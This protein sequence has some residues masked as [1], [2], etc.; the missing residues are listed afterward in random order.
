MRWV[1]LTNGEHEQWRQKPNLAVE[2]LCRGG[3]KSHVQSI[4]F[5]EASKGREVVSEFSSGPRVHARAFAECVARHVGLAGVPS[6]AVGQDEFGA[7]GVSLFII[8]DEDG[9]EEG[10]GSDRSA[11]VRRL[12]ARGL[13]PAAAQQAHV[14]VVAPVDKAGVTNELGEREASQGTL[15]ARQ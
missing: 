3:V 1:T 13:P 5:L 4:E 11:E 10:E 7:E 14:E 8:R 12:A 2:G 9:A 6:Q 15:L